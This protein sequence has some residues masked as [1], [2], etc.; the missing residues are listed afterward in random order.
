M[1]PESYPTGMLLPTLQLQ[2]GLSA[3][4]YCPSV[5]PAQDQALNRFN[6]GWTYDFTRNQVEVLTMTVQEDC[7]LL[8]IGFANPVRAEHMAFVKSVSLYKGRKAVDSLVARHEGYEQIAGGRDV[9]SYIHFRT[10]FPLPAYTAMTLKVE[11]AVPQT[12]PPV[13]RLLLYRG[14][15]FTRPDVWRGRDRLEWTFEDTQ[16]VGPGEVRRTSSSLSGPILRLVYRRS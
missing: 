5:L 15:P 14:N 9:L 2:P 10:P 3:L 1:D 11:L 4:D 12:H 13:T 16:E 8:S 6:R 7:D